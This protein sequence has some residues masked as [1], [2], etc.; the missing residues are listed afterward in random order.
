MGTFIYGWGDTIS[1]KKM[2][3]YGFCPQ[4]GDFEPYYIGR[5]VFRVHIDYIP[6][7]W[8][9][10][11]RCIACK[12]CKTYREISKEDYKR[13]KQA[14]KPMN[15]SM[16]KKC[17]K[18][19]CR[20][21]DEIRE[22]SPQNVDTIMNSISALYPINDNEILSQHYSTLVAQKLQSTAN[23]YHPRTEA[24]Q[25]SQSAPA[26]KAAAMQAALVAANAASASSARPS[27]TET[28][29]CEC[30]KANVTN[31]CT[32]CGKPKPAAAQPSQPEAQKVTVCPRCGKTNENAPFFCSA[33]GAPM[34]TR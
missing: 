34:N 29:T 26:P 32:S 15:K 22:Y 19:I 13:Y 6:L 21:C 27:A 14:Y 17:Y 11:K 30:G 8:I 20:L 25:I 33:C 1:K 12:N 16:S 23:Y 2:M 5:V 28:W 9:P 24:P 7:V 10:K 18:E 4:C 31:F 3:G